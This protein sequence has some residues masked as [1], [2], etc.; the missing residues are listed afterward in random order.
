MRAKKKKLEKS[1]KTVMFRPN[2]TTGY[3]GPLCTGYHELL[4]LG[5]PGP[6]RLGWKHSFLC[7]MPPSFFK[8]KKVKVEFND[9]LLGCFDQEQAQNVSPF[10]STMGAQEVLAPQCCTGRKSTLDGT[11]LCCRYTSVHSYPAMPFPPRKASYTSQCPKWISSVKDSI[12]VHFSLS[13]F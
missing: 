2:P 5:S 4:P 6:L 8:H 12:I 11:S 7:N 9:C 10:T 13:D 3:Q 1:L